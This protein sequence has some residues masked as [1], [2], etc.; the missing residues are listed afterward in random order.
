MIKF[1]L[2]ISV[3]KWVSFTIQFHWKS[4]SEL[5][6]SKTKWHLEYGLNISFL[7]TWLFR[8][9][10]IDRCLLSLFHWSKF[11]WMGWLSTP[12]VESLSSEDDVGL[13]SFK[14]GFFFIIITKPLR[15]RTPIHLT[16]N[17]RQ[18]CRRGV[19][20]RMVSRYGCRLWFACQFFSV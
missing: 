13:L 16:L 5:E 19:I 14:V 15:A 12:Y 6:K 17:A 8:L 18:V 11:L 2:F 9:R 7:F 10:C 4:L 1:L 3:L 20:A